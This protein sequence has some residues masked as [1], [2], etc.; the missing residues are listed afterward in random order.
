MTKKIK[1]KEILSEY[2]KRKSINATA[3]SL[4]I[5]TDAV[6]K[7]L[8][9]YRVIDTPLTKRIAELR[10]IGMNQ[11]Q[12]A[13]MLEISTSTVCKNTPYDRGSYLNPST[14]KNAE[15]L[16]TW[17]AKKRKETK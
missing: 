17:R 15:K 16:R 2:N 7:T 8:V 6:R 9:G 5:S 3:R 14:S 1:S 12:I 13:E 11:R 4:N 10:Q